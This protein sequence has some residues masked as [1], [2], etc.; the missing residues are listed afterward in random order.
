MACATGPLQPSYDPQS[1]WLEVSW[2]GLSR[3]FELRP[4]EHRAIVV[5]RLRGAHVQI[6]HPRVPEVAFH[7]ERDGDGAC[8]VT[9]YGENVVVDGVRATVAR[10][11][12]KRTLVE[13]SGVRVHVTV[14]DA[15]DPGSC[16]LAESEADAVAASFADEAEV[17]KRLTTTTRRVVFGAESP[18]RAAPSS[19]AND[20]SVTSPRVA[21][22]RETTP[23]RLPRPRVSPPRIAARPRERAAWVT[24]SFFDASSGAL[25]SRRAFDALA[26][27]SERRP[28]PRAVPVRGSTPAT[29]ILVA[30][31]LAVGAASAVRFVDGKTRSVSPASVGAAPESSMLRRAEGLFTSR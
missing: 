4:D 14:G 18:E 26:G 19:D 1:V 29:W 17:T 3:V 25:S 13:I 9:G 23:V 16:A 24:T 20:D 31:V 21:Y 10:L 27:A 15:V 8:L 5:G 6:E 30:C 11:P 12:N 2:A 22:F 28:T 7:L